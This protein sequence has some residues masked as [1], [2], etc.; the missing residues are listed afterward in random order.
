MDSLYGILLS[1]NGELI[2]RPLVLKYFK[3]EQGF[4]ILILLSKL[5]QILISY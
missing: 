2:E 1:L 3:S 4:F 5:K